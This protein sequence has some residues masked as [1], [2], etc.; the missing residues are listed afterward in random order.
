MKSIREASR[1]LVITE[2]PV[3]TYNI[4]ETETSCNI[5]HYGNSLRRALLLE[6]LGAFLPNVGSTWIDKPPPP[7]PYL[8]VPCMYACLP[9]SLLPCLFYNVSSQ[10]PEET[11]DD[12]DATVAVYQTAWAANNKYLKYMLKFLHGTS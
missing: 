2:A 5:D 9:S 11:N 1:N 6:L 8:A 4:D 3:S 10:C 7:P 12:D